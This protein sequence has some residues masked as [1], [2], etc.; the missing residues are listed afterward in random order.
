M[1]PD[2]HT[3]DTSA[4]FLDTTLLAAMK[5]GDQAALASFYSRYSRRVY[6][7]ALRVLREPSA[8]EDV[9]QKIFMQ[10]WRNP[11]S[12]VA[13]HGRLEGWLAVITRNRAIDVLRRRKRL[14]PLGDLP[15]ASR[16]NLA[17]EME[18]SLT[19]DQVKRLV[20]DLPKE[21]RIAL[22]MAF[23]EGMTHGEIAK[24][25]GDPLGTV[26]TRIRIALQT[27]KKGLRNQ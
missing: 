2:P 17:A 15:L 20:A 16:Q 27:L 1:N 9:L 13:L 25:T 24:K 22:E 23:F 11:Q 19:L 10:V 3:V 12:F 26:K 8:A 5:Q 4:T 7:V 21:Q 18:E 6:S 14:E